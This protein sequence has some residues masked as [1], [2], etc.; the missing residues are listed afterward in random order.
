VKSF[1]RSDY[2]VLVTL[3]LKNTN[4]IN[5]PKEYA[6]AKKLLS[7]YDD[8]SFWKGTRLESKRRVLN[9]LAYFLTEDGK[10]FLKNSFFYHLK[11][12]DVNIDAFKT[13]KP[14]LEKEKVG[15]KLRKTSTKKLSILDFIKNDS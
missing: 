11:R 9:S 5:Y 2:N 3:F 6:L 4:N 12:K 10:L 7:T 1:K 8:F 14:L 15:E 13:D